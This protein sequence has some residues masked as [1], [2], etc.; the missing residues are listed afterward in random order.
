MRLKIC[1]DGNYLNLY[2]DT[3][4]QLDITSPVF[5]GDR[6]PGFLP[7]VKAYSFNIPNDAHNRAVLRRPELLDNPQDLLVD[8]GWQVIYSG[9]IILSGR[10]EVEE[11]PR[12]G[13]YKATII[14]GIGGNLNILKETYL[15]QLD[16]GKATLG[17]DDAEVL[18]T[19]TSITQSPGDSDILF[20]T[21]RVAEDA[22]LETPPFEEGDPEPDPVP[23]RYKYAN[24]YRGGSHIREEL[25]YDKPVYSTFIPMIRLHRL[26][27]QACARAGYQLGGVFSSHEHAE[28]LKNLILFNTRTLDEDINFTPG[29]DYEDITLMKEVDLSRHL[30]ELKCNDLIREVCNT[31]C[32]APF[33]DPLSQVLT[34]TPMKEILRD[35]SHMDWT[36]KVFPQHVKSRKLRDLPVSFHYDHTRQDGYA[37]QVATDQHRFA[38]KFF[39]TW[40]EAHA[41]LTLDDFPAIVYIES[42]NEYYRLLGF[43]PPS[44]FAVLRGLGKNLGYINDQ[45]EPAFVPDTDSMLMI[46]KSNE[47]NWSGFN[48]LGT[49][50]MPAFYGE[51]ITPWYDDEGEQVDKAILL[52]YR[53][54]ELDGDGELYPL[55]SSN[56]YNY[57][58]DQVG[59]LS[60]HWTGNTG[61]YNVWW[62]DWHEAIQRMRPVS[63]PTRIDARDL[64]NLNFAKKI[65][66]DKHL[67]FVK[68]VQITI[69]AN[70]INTASVEYMQIN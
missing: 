67:Y 33:V 42:Y 27:E 3:S 49:E 11:A 24:R 7:N 10:I 13:A 40:D 31:F 32:W 36:G 14:G 35:Q 50:C 34:I 22:G 55:A 30:P 51:L 48:A 18:G 29:T 65:R 43:R 44:N 8:E 66:I 62:K 9:N 12:S 6:P 63:F 26:M 38:T 68:R 37:E 25:Q 21:V 64:A 16:L 47:P 17:Q 52:F 53:G 5:F 19:I 60:L 39:R 69:N 2:P 20:P 57:D 61:L 56:A 23:T 58:S 41:E 54:L 45:Q 70:S 46:T 15:N 1:K 28:E 4:L 59:E